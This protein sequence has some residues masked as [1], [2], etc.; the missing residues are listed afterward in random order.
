V[1]H[2][3]EREQPTLAESLVSWREVIVISD[4]RHH[5]DVHRLARPRA[6]APLGER[7]SDLDVRVIGEEAVDFGDH[8][9]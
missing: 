7:A 2:F 9:G 8:F 4:A 6:K 3:V 1:C 5:H